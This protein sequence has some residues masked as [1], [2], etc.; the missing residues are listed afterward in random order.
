[1]SIDIYD[2]ELKLDNFYSGI[3][4]SLSI[5]NHSCNLSVVKSVQGLSVIVTA[6]NP[7]KKGK[8]IFMS[9]GPRYN[10]MTLE[11]RNKEL[12][13]KHYFKCYCKACKK[14]WPLYKGE[15]PMFLGGKCSDKL[16]QQIDIINDEFKN[17][18]LSLITF[19]SFAN[20]IP[21]N[22]FYNIEIFGK[23]VE[24]T[25]YKFGKNSP[26]YLYVVSIFENFLEKWNCP[27][28]S[29]DYSYPIPNKNICKTDSQ[30]KRRIRRRQVR[31]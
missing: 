18:E 9:Y 6:I 15:P 26:E 11:E 22:I 27:N 3:F 17:A 30:R 23:L 8:Q 24:K 1:M 25:Y 28:A 13:N 21:D 29:L 19:G 7:I 5:F 20:N 31:Y 4:S 16:F 10:T 2:N 12:I 14:N